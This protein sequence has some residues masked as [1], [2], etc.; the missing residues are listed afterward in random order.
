MNKTEVF[1]KIRNILARVKNIEDPSIIK[2]E[3]KLRDDI[4]VDS[5]D[6][7]D[8]SFHL[9]RE[10]KIALNEKDF[11]VRTKQAWGEK[12]YEKDGILTQ[13]ALVE[14][15]K[16]LPEVPT[17]ELPDNL[18]TKKLANVFRVE[19]LVKVIMKAMDEQ[20]AKTND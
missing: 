9:Q 19:T 3:S 18:E 4:G 12:K 6:M 10:F 2:L 1:E 13:E 11:V 8:L 16:A 5:L 20:H 7:L 17:E 14:L 15:R